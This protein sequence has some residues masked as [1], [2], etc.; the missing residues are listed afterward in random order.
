MNKMIVNFKN[1]I[2]AVMLCSIACLCNSVNAQLPDGSIGNTQYIQLLNDNLAEET[3]K[4]FDPSMA[5][6][7]VTIPIYVF[8]TNNARGEAA[9][10]ES[11]ITSAIVDVNP[12]FEPIGIN[13]ELKEIKYIP[14]YPYG[15]QPDFDGDIEVKVKYEIESVLNLFLVDTILVDGA[16]AYYGFTFF[17]VDTTNNSIF[18]DKDFVTSKNLATQIGHFLGLL[19]TYDIVAGIEL[20]DSSNCSG[21]GDM[22]C[23]TWADPGILG[24]VNGDCEYTG[25]TK[26]PNADWYVPSVANFMTDGPDYCKCIFTNEQYRRMHYY[27]RNYRSYLR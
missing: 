24:M 18:L 26:D 12:Y 16:T 6:L 27:Y 4:P 25:W 22:I 21:A 15:V 1:S 5:G 10:E 19:S 7:S 11:V 8:V 9:I 17:P 14:E 2:I 23:D 13:F 20:V 3:A